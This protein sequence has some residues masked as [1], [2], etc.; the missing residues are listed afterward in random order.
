MID[1]FISLRPRKPGN[2]N[3]YKKRS[4][5][6]RN[7]LAF[8]GL[9]IRAPC[10]LLRR[11]GLRTSA[12]L[13]FA[14]ALSTRDLG[15]C[16][17]GS[18]VRGRFQGPALAAM[19]GYQT[20]AIYVRFPNNWS[21]KRRCTWKDPGMWFLGAVYK[22]VLY[23]ITISWKSNQYRTILYMMNSNIYGSIKW[24]CSVPSSC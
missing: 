16:L 12:R 9:R 15:T 14:W 20:S 8:L 3:L 1:H 13:F 6:R 11:L 24:S 23:L 7:M 2:F 10:R 4:L 19:D 5:G 17:R 21:C 18:S 22:F